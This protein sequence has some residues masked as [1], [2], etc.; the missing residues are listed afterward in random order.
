MIS[1]VNLYILKILL[2]YELKKGYIYPLEP[3]YTHPSY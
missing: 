1:I 3:E 2:K